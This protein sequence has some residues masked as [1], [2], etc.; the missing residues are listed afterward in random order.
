[1]VVEKAG[2]ELVCSTYR[3]LLPFLHVH[4]DF[5]MFDDVRLPGSTLNNQRS[6]LAYLP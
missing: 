5:D 3:E 6:P 2:L 4:L 1:M